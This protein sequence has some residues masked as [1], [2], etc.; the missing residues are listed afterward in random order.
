MTSRVRPLIILSTAMLLLAVLL[1]LLPLRTL[2][3]A[4]SASPAISGD[5]LPS[6][7]LVTD[8]AGSVHLY[9][10]LRQSLAAAGLASQLVI[11]PQDEPETHEDKLMAAAN[12]LQAQSEGQIWLLLEGGAFT[13]LTVA[14]NPLIQGYIILPHHIDD[15]KADP[16]VIEQLD[17]QP[18]LLLTSDQPDLRQ[19]GAMFFEKITGEDATLLPRHDQPDRIRSTSS[20]PL[21]ARSI[22]QSS[23]ACGHSGHRL[24]RESARSSQ[25]KLI[26]CPPAAVPRALPA[27]RQPEA[28]C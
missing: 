23:T 2:F 9:T 27:T 12:S 6:V 8:N 14:E 11:L 4:S 25:R 24:I 1:V 13:S 19:A 22:I 3:S 20:G 5:R 16:A 15:L 10:G 7:L 28:L 21:T 18:L 26:A 17:R